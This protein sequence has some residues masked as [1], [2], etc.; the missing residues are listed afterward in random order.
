MFHETRLLIAKHESQTSQC[1]SV[2]LNGQSAH[3]VVMIVEQQSAGRADAVHLT[4][5]QNAA[6]RPASR[7]QRSIPTAGRNSDSISNASRNSDLTQK[8]CASK[9]DDSGRLDGRSRPAKES[10]GAAALTAPRCWLMAA[11][12]ALAAGSQN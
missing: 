8:M 9:Q 12:A 6:L 7:W 3:P 11:L 1:Y 5:L 2:D 4:E 10:A